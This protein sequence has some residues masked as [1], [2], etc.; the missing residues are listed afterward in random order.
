VINFE[1][2]D[3]CRDGRLVAVA[4]VRV[5][6]GA[7]FFFRDEGLR[8]GLVI[9]VPPLLD[10]GPVTEHPIAADPSEIGAAIRAVGGKGHI[11]GAL[12]D[13]GASRAVALL[14]NA[15][16]AGP[17]CSL[18]LTSVLHNEPRFRGLV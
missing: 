6:P 4:V 16:G 5:L 18:E 11:S 1:R 10:A 2:F 13:P 14:H 3:S 7:L 12:G 8:W 17:S 9:P 15:C